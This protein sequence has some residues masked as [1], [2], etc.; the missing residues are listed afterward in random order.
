MAG[1]GAHFVLVHG[2]WHASWCWDQLK[3]DLESKGHTVDAVDLP[4]RADPAEASATTLDDCVALVLK[5]VSASP[6]PVVLVA[7]SFGGITATQAAALAPDRI[8]HLVYLCAFVPRDGECML[9]LAA[10]EEFQ[11]SLA[12]RHQ[13]LDLDHG[14]SYPPEDQAI[15]AFFGTCDPEAARTAAGRLI[16][17]GLA[18]FAQP[19]SAGAD[20]VGRLR[21]TYIEARQDRAIPIAAQ[22]AMRHAAGI[23]DVR[24][25]DSDHSPFLSRPGELAG[26]L[27]AIA[28]GGSPA[29][30]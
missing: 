30:L 6:D 8:R 29:G 1:T 16:P 4:G 22:R 28:S 15:E 3:L 7:H 23:D 17:E 24:T 20:T 10:A 2:A 14:L 19:V 25:I 11:P 13:R 9:D 12:A 26:I 21:R 18:L 27:H 5:R